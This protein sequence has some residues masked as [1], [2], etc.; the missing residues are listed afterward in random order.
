VAEAY[1]N[2]LAGVIFTETV[3]AEKKAVERLY[4]VINKKF[5]YGLARKTDL[6]DA[7]ARLALVESDYIEALNVKADAFEALKTIC[8]EDVFAVTP[9]SRNII[10]QE[11][12]PN[13]VNIW[14]ENALK[15]NLELIFF[16]YKVK[17]ARQEKN[18]QLAGHIPTVDVVGQYKVESSSGDVLAGGGGNEIE[19]K[20]IYVRLNVPLFEGGYTQSKVTEAVA[21]L[22]QVIK[23]RES[24]R[25]NTKREIRSAFLQV[26]S[27]IIK[28]KALLSSLE[29]QK[30]AVKARRKGFEAGLYNLL[31]VLDAERIRYIAERDYETA[32]FDYIFSSLKLKQVVGSLSADDIRRINNFF[33]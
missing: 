31:D 30:L 27:S 1:L 12:E 8:N 6:Y 22:N 2:A 3:E 14:Q 15:N 25:R 17:I 4:N 28:S 13:D 33:Q 21:V 32:R 16:N 23:T 18:K 5:T 11:P 10:M 24:K 26:Q 19:S 20:D 7:K 9:L 29:S